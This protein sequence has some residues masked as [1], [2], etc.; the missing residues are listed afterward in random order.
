MTRAFRCQYALEN[1]AGIPA[2]DAWYLHTV[3]PVYWLPTPQGSL[4]KAGIP[5]CDAQGSLHK[6]GIP[7][8]NVLRVIIYIQNYTFSNFSNILCAQY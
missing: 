4:C 2:S 8:S 6:A 5:A 7:A 1:K 3:P